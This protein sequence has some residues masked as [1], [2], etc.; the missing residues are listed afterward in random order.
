MKKDNKGQASSKKE[1][2]GIVPLGDRVLI[3]PLTPEEAGRTL[4]SGIIIPET[5]DKEKSEQGRVI[6]VGQGKRSESG[7]LI[8]LSVKVGDKIMFSKYGY[9][10]VKIGGVEYLMVSEAS[11]LAILK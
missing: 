9:D 8:P 10:E 5:I 2:V 6:A 3:K 4:V 7:S 11:I 1:G